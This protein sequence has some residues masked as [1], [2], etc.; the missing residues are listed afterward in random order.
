MFTWLGRNMAWSRLRGNVMQVRATENTRLCVSAVL[1]LPAAEQLGEHRAEN[2]LPQKK[3]EHPSHQAAGL[4]LCSG[5]GVCLIPALLLRGHPQAPL[6]SQTSR[7]SLP[8]ALGFQ[9]SLRE[10]EA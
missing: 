10:R 1:R 5:S 2:C 3:E 6:Q 7:G 8:W 9:M 4:H